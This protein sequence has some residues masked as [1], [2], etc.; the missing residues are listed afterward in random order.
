MTAIDHDELQ[1]VLSALLHGRTLIDELV[2]RG[3]RAAG[4]N[5]YG[6]LEALRDELSRVG[7][8]HLAEQLGALAEA[9]RNDDPEAPAGLLRAQTSLQLFDRVLTLRVVEAGLAVAGQEVEA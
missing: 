4:P 8:R 2:V 7:A 3:V 1:E 5:E 6:R 9:V